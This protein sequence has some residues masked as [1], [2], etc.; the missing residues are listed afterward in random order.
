M[1]RTVLS[2]WYYLS[3]VTNYSAFICISP[4]V[5]IATG[6]ATQWVWRA[7]TSAS[8]RVSF[9]SPVCLFWDSRVSL[10]RLPCVSLLGPMET[11]HR[12]LSGLHSGAP[13]K[14]QKF[15]NLWRRRHRNAAELLTP[16][17]HYCCELIIFFFSV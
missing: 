5:C 2:L 8:L 6:R 16:P 13:F 9:E 4:P 14:R 17:Y 10:L 11:V 1:Q 3:V 12:H 15:A 7:L